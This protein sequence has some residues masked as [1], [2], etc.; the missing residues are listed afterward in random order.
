MVSSFSDPSMFVVTLFE[1]LK[2]RTSNH[3]STLVDAS[4]AYQPN[5]TSQSTDRASNNIANSEKVLD[6]IVALAKGRLK[7]KRKVSR[8]EIVVNRLKNKIKKMKQ[9]QER[10]TSSVQ[11]RL[12]QQI[13]CL[14]RPGTMLLFSDGI[15]YQ[16][17]LVH[18]VDDQ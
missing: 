15:I 12:L 2:V 5:S 14:P 9:Q 1:D 4:M 16:E 13:D 11:Y 18:H 6:P 17:L 8:C 7:S 3:I 10:S